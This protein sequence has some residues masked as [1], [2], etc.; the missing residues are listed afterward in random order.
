MSAELKAKLSL[1][2]ADY[3]RAKAHVKAGNHEMD[4]GFKELQHRLTQMFTVGFLIEF[5]NQLVER[6]KQ[7]RILSEQLD[8]SVETA[9]AWDIG[10]KE[11]GQSAEKLALAIT[12][13]AEARKKA[14]LDPTGAEAQMFGFFKIGREKLMESP[15]EI[16]RALSD[17]M[18]KTS[19]TAKELTELSSLIGPK[20]ATALR[21]TLG[22]GLTDIEKKLAH[23][24]EVID[25]S[26]IRKMH[27]MEN[28]WESLQRKIQ[29]G[30]AKGVAAGWDAI[31]MVTGWMSSGQD[32]FM[33]NALFTP[34]PWIRGLAGALNWMTGGGDGL[35]AKGEDAVAK[36]QK[37][38]ADAQKKRSE[39]EQTRAEIE[40]GNPV[41]PTSLKSGPRLHH[42]AATNLVRLGNF[43]FTRGG[44]NPME[45]VLTR[46]MQIQQ[47]IEANT[48]PNKGVAGGDSGVP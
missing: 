40:Q 47:K 13:I 34:G 18:S 23:T 5:G 46:S 15:V 3:D 42:Q 6:A 24:G 39:K 21:V 16:L 12:K 36:M 27:E 48:R 33:S 37:R 25:E 26:V 41:E 14:L 2:T 45:T 20:L 38:L 4:F 44:A 1:N 11:N 7:V 31:K 28:A 30:G 17:Q 19:R 10:L 22:E 9:Q 32:D 29:A 43:A 8:V 35:D